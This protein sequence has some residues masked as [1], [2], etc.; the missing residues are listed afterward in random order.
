MKGAPLGNLLRTHL[1]G[2]FA[3]RTGGGGF[4]LLSILWLAAGSTLPGQSRLLL[5][6]IECK[7]LEHLDPQ[8][9]A[10]T[11]GLAV[12]S[13]IDEGDIQRACRRL[14]ATGYFSRVGY[15]Y[16]G[17]RGKLV[18]EFQ[19]EEFQP[20][21]PVMFDNLVGLSPDELDQELRRKLP[22]YNGTIPASNEAEQT[23]R[24]IVEDFLRR[25]GL[26]AGLELTDYSDVE[27]NV[28]Y[29]VL[30]L[31]GNV[32]PLAQIEFPGAPP[33]V[34]SELQ[35][36]VKPLLDRP[37]STAK[38]LQLAS[39]KLRPLLHAQ[40]YL[41]AKLGTPQA[42]P[43]ETPVTLESAVRAYLP[44]ESGTRFR[45][46]E[47]TWS[48]A[49]AF[50]PE[51]LAQLVNLRP[52]TL[53]DMSALEEGIRRLKKAYWGKGFAELKVDHEINADEERG[54]A[55]LHFV[56]REGPQYRMGDLRMEGVDPELAR[57]IRSRW[58]LAPGDV[59]DPDYPAVFEAQVIP[60]IIQEFFRR[61]GRLVIPDYSWIPDPDR[62]IVDV[63]F[64][65]R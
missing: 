55:H 18:V 32:F 60:E 51:R 19:L 31:R 20:A 50:P 10:A 48:G 35:R 6:A 23:I 27:A 45:W 44:I 61:S 41:R 62:K 52:G 46:G 54:T 17:E 1:P 8:A 4:F 11:A 12:G 65:M 13:P 2:W 40:G 58:K 9:V 36:A 49:H 63:V 16:R 38:L 39:E 42:E 53:A 29:V 3:K 47:L 21:F 22:L 33:E 43:L 34:V 7:G 14:L 64:R 30:R 37:Y 57:L 25:Q 59:F 24:A 56:V 26:A 28:D 15:R 5:Q